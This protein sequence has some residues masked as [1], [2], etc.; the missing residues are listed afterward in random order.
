MTLRETILGWIVS[1]LHLAPVPI[2]MGK[3]RV[4][5]RVLRPHLRLTARRGFPQGCHP[6]RVPAR[7][8]DEGPAF[9]FRIAISR[10]GQTPQRC[11]PGSL[12]TALFRLS[13]FLIPSP[14][15]RGYRARNGMSQCATVVDE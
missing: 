4:A 11:H 7:R 5:S 8:D 3:P 12:K 6:E 14:G 13:L 1:P 9:T 2:G 15:G 10:A